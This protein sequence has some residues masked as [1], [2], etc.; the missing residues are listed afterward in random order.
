MTSL[1]ETLQGSAYAGY[2]Y[3][4]PH[5]TAYRP[6]SPLRPLDEVWASERKD[7]LFLYLHVPFCEFRCGFCNLFTRALPPEDLAG[8]YLN[9]LRKEA[10]RVRAQLGDA[11][12]VRLAI[13]GGTPTYLAP[14]ELEE[15]FTIVQEVMGATPTTIP[16]GI[17]CSPATA[18]ADRLKLLRE[19]GVDRVSIGIQSFDDSESA[20][21]GRPQ[22]GAHAMEALDRIAS[23]GFAT[24]NIDLIYGGAGQTPDRFCESIRTALR[25]RP[26]ELYLYPLYVRPL[27]GLGRRGESWDDQR[28]ACYRAGRE[29]LIAEGYEQV[30]MRMFR[31]A[32]A[33]NVVDPP[34]ACQTDGMVGLG[35]GARSYTRDL[36]YSTE[37]AVGRAG[38]HEILDDYLARE[39]DDFLHAR[40]GFELDAE[41]RQRRFAILSLLQDE[42][43]SLSEFQSAHGLEL[44]AALPELH[45]LLEQRFA[46]FVDED[47]LK[48]TAAGMERSD[49]IGPWLFSQRVHSLM[50]QYTCR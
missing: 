12:F 17:E 42:G 25:W 39:P 24:R 43:L 21:I 40:Y 23:T 46:I 10:E 9:Q 5:K 15:L 16:V 47:R 2:V 44:L 19:F 18:T 6:L 33:P 50:E 14:N 26:E 31:L 37:Y 41:D 4:Y 30:S 32:S 29:L 36:H 3:S 13:G 28:L 8:R 48:L 20:A 34:Y 7:S 45:E 35:C 27:T 11:T 1:M 38:V 49:A 22:D